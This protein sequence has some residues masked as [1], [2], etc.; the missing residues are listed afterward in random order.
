VTN[1][2][3]VAVGIHKGIISM[4]NPRYAEV[5]KLLGQLASFSAS[6]QASYGAG[7]AVYRVGPGKHSFTGHYRRL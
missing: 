7:E 1:G 2:L 3:D 5:W 4:S 6:G